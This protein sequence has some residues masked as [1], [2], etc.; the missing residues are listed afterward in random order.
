[1]PYSYNWSGPN[2]YFSSSANINNAAAG[3]YIVT[4]TDSSGCSHS[5]TSAVGEPIPWTVS[6]QIT[7]IKCAGYNIGAIDISV[8]G[9]TAPYIY[10]WSTGAKTQDIS[11]LS[12]GVYTVNITDSNACTISRTYSI[13]SP[14]SLS[15]TYTST[16]VSCNRADDG[17]LTLLASGGTFPWT[18]SIAGP[19]G[20][21]SSSVSN[22]SLTAGNYKV[23]LSDQNN[24]FDSALVIITEPAIFKATNTVTQPEC[25]GQ[26][27]SFSLNVSGG[28]APYNY[29]WLDASGSLYSATQNVVSVDK[30]RYKFRITDAKQCFFEDSSEIVEPNILDVS[31]SGL[32]HNTCFN[33]K[34]GGLTLNSTGGTT[35]YQY[36]LNQGSLQTS[37]VFSSLATGN[38]IAWV[39]DKNNC[40]DTVNF[41]IEYRDAIKPTVALKNITR[42]LNAT[43]NLTISLSEVDNGI[44]DNCGVSSTSISPNSFNCQNLGPNTVTV[45]ATDL[46]G[47]Q[48]SQTCTVTVFDTLVPQ[49]KTKA[50]SI[51]LNAAGAATLNASVLND[52][53]SDNCGITSLVASQNNFSCT[54]LGQNSI[55]LSATDASGN[56]SQAVETVNVLDTIAPILKYR[57]RI[58]FLNSTG[59]VNITPADVD[60]KSTDNCGIATYQISQSIFDCNELGTNFIDFTITDQSSNK[61]TQSVRITVR[62]TFA[63]VLKTK[64]VTLFLNQ[65]GFAV[66]APSDIDDGSTDNCKISTRNLSQS[67]FTCGNLGSNSILYTL[68]DLSGNVSSGRVSV[69]VRDTTNPI[70][71]IR[72]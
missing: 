11:S 19:S 39:I 40:T 26:K 9:N 61:V 29:E 60:D 64:P 25:F 72:K 24:C 21:T 71:K 63:P 4:I 43:G 1:M 58:L 67:V 52:A 54:H 66:L 30:G 47:N 17:S 23:I 27:G 22:K 69:T 36:R 12:A 5:D 50:A 62:D 41:T 53:S 2:S 35:P 28:T 68:T 3:T 6:Q 16:N 13:T 56:K 65:Y 59:S 70:N 44:T 45:T 48:T 7:D 37:S 32:T 33:D 51:Y 20:F 8:G 55:T 34:S 57:N 14:Q 15:L 18:Y 10:S 42:Y 46:K 49:L 38:F 31:V